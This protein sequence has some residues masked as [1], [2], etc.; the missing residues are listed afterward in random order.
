MDYTNTSAIKIF[1]SAIFCWYSNTLHE[2]IVTFYMVNNRNEVSAVKS[3]KFTKNRSLLAG[4]LEI[5][6]TK[7]NTQENLVLYTDSQYLYNAL[8][9]EPKEGMKNQDLLELIH[10]S[11]KFIPNLHPMLIDDNLILTKCKTLAMKKLKNKA[12]VNQYFKEVSPTKM[13]S[14]D[15]PNT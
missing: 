1:E 6:F 4:V 13:F 14:L 2:S 10:K 15:L 7:F 5:L 3:Y 12:L 9:R 11:K 8:T